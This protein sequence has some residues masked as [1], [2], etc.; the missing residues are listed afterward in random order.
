MI[1]SFEALARA[2]EEG[3][4]LAVSAMVVAR[5]EY[6]HV[7]PSA[8]PAGMDDLAARSGIA[9]LGHP[10]SRL[11]RLR[12]FLFEEQGFRGNS[13]DYFD[14]RNSCLNVVLE[15]RLGIPLTLSI[16]LMEV[17]RRVG[18]SMEGVALPGHFLTRAR[19]DDGDVLI[20]PF[21][22]GALLSEG[23]AECVVEL[24]VGR[25][26]PLC[27]SDFDAASKTAILARMLGNLKGVYTKREEWTKALSV[28]DLLRA[29][30]KDGPGDL[31]DRGTILMKLGQ[32]HAG[33]A[34]W[35]E[36]LGRYPNAKDAIRL[37][38]QLRQI[39]QALASLN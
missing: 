28:L 26:I 21:H 35:D 18:L 25:H 5:L 34:E 12:R 6:P 39:R 16:V 19:F 36:Y 10:R 14:P 9:Q 11:S 4:D 13:E 17:G 3:I 32:F 33:A 8:G 31:R 15:R 20:D 1:E 38:G 7:D 2:G 29:L 37:R 22:G 27:R 30:G 23:D 24:A